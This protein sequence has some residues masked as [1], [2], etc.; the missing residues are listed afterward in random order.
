MDTLYET[1][2]LKAAQDVF[3]TAAKDLETDPYNRLS[4]AR[5]VGDLKEYWLRYENELESMQLIQCE[6][7]VNAQLGVTHGSDGDEWKIIYHGAIDKLLQSRP[8]PDVP[9][10]IRDHKTTSYLTAN[11][12]VS[13]MLS[14]QMIG[15]AA[16]VKEFFGYEKIVVDVDIVGITKVR[17]PSTFLRTEIVAS[18]VLLN[19]WRQEIQQTARMM[20]SCYETGIW[21]RYGERSCFMYGR[22]CDF[23]DICS[24]DP[25][26]RP[27]QVKAHYAVDPWD[28][29]A[30][31]EDEKD[32]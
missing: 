11:T 12:G 18:D 29:A 30:R 5:G 25:D 8:G 6:A 32:A 10:R 21:P 28:P 31:R 9:V 26:F 3:E 13:Y 20:L 4:I 16:L 23:F 27:V 15:Y 1:K 17:P 7:I 19:E 22:R 14:N 24:V 2:D